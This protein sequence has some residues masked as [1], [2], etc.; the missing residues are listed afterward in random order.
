MLFLCVLR[1]TRIPRQWLQLSATLVLTSGEAGLVVRFSDISNYYSVIVD[2]GA[3]TATL[4]STVGGVA[5]SLASVAVPAA[6]VT[7][8]VTLT[9]TTDDRGLTFTVEHSTAVQAL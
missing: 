1:G 9:L 5:Q 7:T 3:A 8:R 4:Y 2:A 6:L